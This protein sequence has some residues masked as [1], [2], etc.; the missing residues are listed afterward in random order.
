MMCDRLTRWSFIP[1]SSKVGTLGK[2]LKRLGVV[3]AKALNLP[4]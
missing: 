3:T 2:V 4:F 1:S